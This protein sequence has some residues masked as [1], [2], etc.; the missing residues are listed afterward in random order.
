MWLEENKLAANP[1]PTP[2]N[3]ASA[4]TSFWLRCAKLTVPD[5]TDP[6]RA[7]LHR[8]G[9]T[10]ETIELCG[11]FSAD[12]RAGAE[13][14]GKPLSAD[15]DYAG[16]V[17]TYYL[18]GCDDPRQRRIRRTHA[19][20]EI[21]P[22]RTRKE[23][24]KYMVYPGTRNMF[25]IPRGTPAEWLTDP[26]ILVIFVEGEFKA[27]IVAQTY[28]LAGRRALVI[29][30]VG[31]WGW[32]GS[33]AKEPTA[34]GGTRRSKGLNSDFERIKWIGR[35]AT[36]CFDGDIA[37][38]R[39]VGIARKAFVAALLNLQA[40]V[41]IAEVA[42]A[43]H[44]IDDLI[45]NKGAAAGLTLLDAAEPAVRP[46]TVEFEDAPP[47][48]MRRPLTIIDGRGYAAVWPYARVTVNESTD[49]KGKVVKHDPPRIRIEQ[50]LYVVRDDGKMFDDAGRPHG[51]SGERL[52]FPIRLPERP[53]DRLLWSKQ[54]FERYRNG[55][56][57]NPR[58]VFER[59]TQVV[60]RFIDFNRSFGD[61]SAMCELTACYILS[62]WYIEAVNVV[63]Y[64]WPSGETGSGK[65]QFL[66]VVTE[67]AYLGQLLQASGS[68]AC[69]RDL[70]D[71]GAC[72]GFDDAEKIGDPKAT[73][74]DKRALLLAGNRRGVTIPVKESNGDRT[75]RTRYVN[76]FCSKLF[77][78]I[79]LPDPVLMTRVIMMFL[80]RTND[81]QRS[82]N[83][84]ADPKAWPEKRSGLV[85]DLW[86]L[87]LQHVTALSA[88]ESWVGD[89]ARLHGRLLEPW[90]A[91]LSVA[92]WLDD[93]GETG[94]WARMESLSMKYQAERQGAG[95]DD[96][97]VAILH[98]LCKLLAPGQ[99]A[100]SAIKTVCAI[101]SEAIEGDEF[102]T[103]RIAE[104]AKE[105][106][107]ELELDINLDWIAARQVGRKLGALRFE[108]RRKDG[109]GGRGWNIRRTLV[110]DR[111]HA[112]GLTPVDLPDPDA[113]TPNINGTDGTNGTN[114]TE[115]G[116][117]VEVHEGRL[118]V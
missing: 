67:L 3:G 90:K 81:P 68:F 57:P 116:R 25:Y 38:N 107:T 13:I 105:A 22:D 14:V 34:N 53:E 112:L 31:V 48:T 7:S 109:K 69:L 46:E 10:D 16:I 64:L 79:R 35:V 56:R 15:Y 60:D 100:I 29:G 63:G 4:A 102:S 21:K 88:Y 75:W 24:N 11:F 49:S 23:K 76:G 45:V 91:L 2:P 73:D 103:A 9:L 41:R 74:P 50:R 36:V 5:L 83:D 61:Q 12:P 26:S 97:Q 117:L 54:G 82:N 89:N 113:D 66:V 43:D 94:L 17:A 20:I 118:I 108:S 77:S 71:Y 27:A 42:V 106:A 72:M 84:P 80:V 1:Q 115:P 18:P 44:A 98:G 58:D 101:T 8:R 52:A 30:I 114:G 95:V 40:V 96:L 110:R 87:G 93:L 92:K 111:V 78:A 37:T 6:D 47:A 99:S 19:D 65:T 51:H 104:A 28:R 32:R 39:W 59:L 85:D 55:Q 86:A 62:T 33:G 70:A